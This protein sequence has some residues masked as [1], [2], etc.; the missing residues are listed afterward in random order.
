ME[1]IRQFEEFVETILKSLDYS[2][3]ASPSVRG[4]GVDWIGSKDMQTVLV[5]AKY[6]QNPVSGAIY[7]S[8]RNGASTLSLAT[9]LHHASKADVLLLVTSF[10]VSQT[11]ID[12]YKE[13]Y[14]IEIWDLKRLSEIATKDKALDKMYS[15]YLSN[16]KN[17]A[18][19]TRALVRESPIYVDL[20]QCLEQIPPGRDNFRDYEDVCIDILSYVFLPPFVLPPEIQD[21]SDDKLHR[22]DAIYRLDTGDEIWDRI[23]SQFRTRFVLAEFKNLTGET[24]QKEVVDI[25]RYLYPDA[26]RS[27]GFLCGRNE[28]DK[29]AIKLR[30]S[31]WRGSRKLVL[32]LS[33][34][35]MKDLLELKASGNNPAEHIDHKIDLFLMGLNP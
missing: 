34:T 26:M 7:S 31:E 35:E 29:S 2:I 4:S 10:S 17:I 8:L 19:Q 16:L 13:R 6:L 22:R 28:P 27:L 3:I 14:S 33:D 12:E 18:T 11:L 24:G 20:K 21:I 5:E 1:N 15:V 32:F 25:C 9:R 23:Q 30:T